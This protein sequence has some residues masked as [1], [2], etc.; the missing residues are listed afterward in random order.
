MITK[1]LSLCLAIFSLLYMAN[2][3]TIATSYG[4]P[5]G[6][7]RIVNTDFENDGVGQSPTEWAL[8]KGG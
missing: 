4:W 7:N 6:Q 3:L 2:F 5:I 1:R 8:E